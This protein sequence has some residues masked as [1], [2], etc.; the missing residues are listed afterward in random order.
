MTAHLNGGTAHRRPIVG[1][2]TQTLQSLGG[3]SAEIPP[4][5]VMSQRYVVTLTNAGAIPWLIPL[6]DDDTLR[7]LYESLDGVFLPGGADIDPVSYGRDPHSLCDKTDRE[8]DRVELALARWALAD[9]K[10]ILGVCR[11]MQLINVAAGGTLF[12]DIAEQM[13]GAIRHDYFPFSAP[14]F[15]RD[16][17]AHDVNVVAGTRLASTFGA[18]RLA[19]NSMHHQGVR[20][21]GSGLEATATA[22]DGLIEALESRGGQYVVGVQWHPEALTDSE[23]RARRLF[24]EFVETAATA[25]AAARRRPRSMGRSASDA[26][27]SVT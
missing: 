22:P 14:G 17:L 9:G 12:E 10:P 23:E 16:Y 8:R 27:Q 6:I 5:W 13:P 7:G 11:G 18:G 26:D 2:P 25:S 24:R 1:I 20:D 19:V 21:L 3:V 4:S 15:S